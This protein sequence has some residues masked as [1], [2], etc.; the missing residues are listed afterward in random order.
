MKPQKPRPNI[1]KHVAI[2]TIIICLLESLTKGW[3]S[4]ILLPAS[5]IF[6]P[7]YGLVMFVCTRVSGSHPY[8]KYLRL[9]AY[10]LSVI[11]AVF[12]I[13]VVGVG[14]SEEVLLFGF[15]I[16]PVGSPPVLLSTLISVLCFVLIPVVIFAM[17]IVFMMAFRSK[18]KPVKKRA[19]KWRE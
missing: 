7:I 14:D 5:L 3:V 19:K 17:F 18:N 8:G 2:I 10:A 1:L 11:V 9:L 4:F 15:L 6:L 13:S 16:S 12:Y